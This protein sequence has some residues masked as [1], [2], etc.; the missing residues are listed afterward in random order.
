MSV[1]FN[2]ATDYAPNRLAPADPLARPK[3]LL[4]HDWMPTLGG[5]ENVFE[6]ICSMYA[7][8]VVSALVKPNL[9]PWLND[10][11][12]QS[13]V[14]QNLPFAFWKH[15]LFAPW[16]PNFYRHVRTAGFDIVLV[17]SHSFAHHVSRSADVPYLCY[18][19]TSARSLWN[20]EI[21]DR[22]VSGRL[23]WIRRKIADRLRDLDLRASR[24]PSYLVANSQTT[25]ER[26]ERN[27]GRLVDEVIY[28]PVNVQKWSDTPRIDHSEGFLMWGRLIGYKRI[29][30]AIEAAKLTGFKL[31][32]VGSGPYEAKLRA[33]V[34]DSGNI[35]FH[36]RLSDLDLKVLMSKSVG[37]LFP[38]YEDFGIV[39]VEAMA[40]G[41]PVIAYGQGGAAETVAGFGLLL[42]SQD[43]FELARKMTEM[44]T[45]SID[46]SALRLHA[47]QFDT[48]VF[49]E[50]YRAA[51]ETA[52]Q[53][54]KLS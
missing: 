49:R 30:L 16:M 34:G 14:F 21:D 7:G 33:L 45:L 53:R 11:S 4:V 10:R 9:F 20:P 52:I 19:H 27:Y 22:A 39:P 12:V 41:L 23:A 1:I 28:P 24:N 40:A 46:Y 37:V 29:D 48:S 50:K 8:P 32:I 35:H 31:N 5:S 44:S 3:T 54:I 42:D 36:G 13:S 18:Y 47:A 51:V 15:Y 38:G 25:A 26:I 2:R 17:D 43:P 6:E